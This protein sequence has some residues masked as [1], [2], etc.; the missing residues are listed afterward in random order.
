MTATVGSQGGATQGSAEQPAA[1]DY[2]TLVLMNPDQL[3]RVNTYL[4]LS[5][6]RQAATHKETRAILDH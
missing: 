5:H 3:A 4:E 2:V 6:S 1:S